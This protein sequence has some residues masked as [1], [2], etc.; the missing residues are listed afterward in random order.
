MAEFNTTGH[1]PGTSRAEGVRGVVGGVWILGRE[2]R[3]RM[4]AAARSRA[5]GSF[6]AHAG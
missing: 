5:P 1:R 6:V 2:G 3:G 4:S